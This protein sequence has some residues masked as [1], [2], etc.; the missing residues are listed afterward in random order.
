MKASKGTSKNQANVIATYDVV[1]DA[2]KRV[3]LRGAKVK[4]FHVKALSDGRYLLEPRVLVPPE[5]V[6]PRVLKMLNAS[7]ENLKKGKVSKPVNLP[8]LDED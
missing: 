2:K 7:A 5:V 6:P 8:S 1:V 3:S 4:H